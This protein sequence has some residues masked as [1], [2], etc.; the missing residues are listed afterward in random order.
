MGNIS[1]ENKY[2]LINDTDISRIK[3]AKMFIDTSNNPD[4]VVEDFVKLALKNYNILY[5]V[6]DS[7]NLLK[8]KCNSKEGLILYRDAYLEL[9]KIKDSIYN[10]EVQ[11]FAVS[12]FGKKFNDLSVEELGIFKEIMRFSINVYRLNIPLSINFKPIAYA[13]MERIKYERHL[14]TRDYMSILSLAH[15]PGMSEYRRMHIA[16]CVEQDKEVKQR[17]FKELLDLY[18][19]GSERL[20]LIRISNDFING[21]PQGYLEKQNK[22]A[23]VNVDEEISAI[24][25]LINFDNYYSLLHRK[26]LSSLADAF[27][28]GYLGTELNK[29]GLV[30]PDYCTLVPDIE[31]LSMKLLDDRSKEIGGRAIRY[32]PFATK[33]DYAIHRI[34]MLTKKLGLNEIDRK[35]NN[36]QNY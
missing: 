13:N 21:I 32:E 24:L 23:Y 5:G 28:R 10:N 19:L 33:I 35:I 20:A 11:K 7:G 4:A 14:S 12:I 25:D 30:D 15:E 27:L 34:T 17:K 16:Y 6:K 3:L 9:I 31:D 18:H 29:R 8:L 2:A 26:R 36:Y 22:P 1:K